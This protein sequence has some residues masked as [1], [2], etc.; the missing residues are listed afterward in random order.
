MKKIIFEIDDEPSVLIFKGSEIITKAC[1]V[2][3]PSL[4]EE[5]K[6]KHYLRWLNSEGAIYNP[7]TIEELDEDDREFYEESNFYVFRI[8]PQVRKI[9]NELKDEDN[10]RYIYWLEDND[11]LVP[12]NNYSDILDSVEH[13]LTTLVGFDGAAYQ[14]SENET[15]QVIIMTLDWNYED[16]YEK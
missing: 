10:S 15:T 3:I 1:D 11:E 14:V 7:K 13:C 6:A 16:E 8:K 5:Q 2:Y 12:I 9:I 4:T